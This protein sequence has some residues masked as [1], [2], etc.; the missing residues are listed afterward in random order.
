MSRAL[1]RP[2]R[3]P[4][5]GACRSL[6][7]RSA[8]PPSCARRAATSGS[9][10]CARSPAR[11]RWRGRSRRRRAAAG[12]PS[13]RGRA[14]PSR[15]NEPPSSSSPAS[16][17]KLLSGGGGASSGARAEEDSLRAELVAHDA[18][19]FGGRRGGLLQARSGLQRPPGVL[20]HLL[21]RDA[22][23]ERL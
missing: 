10:P 11:A 23:V 4:R 13:S 1:R 21:E 5:R 14:F 12:P 7:P 20:A 6:P 2:D 16:S 9:A 15:R 22:R 19:L 3:P 18:D 17:S 8:P